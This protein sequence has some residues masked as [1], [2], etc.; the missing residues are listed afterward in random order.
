MIVLDMSDKR[1]IYEQIM[2]SIKKQIAMGVFATNDKLP[3]VRQLAIEMSI[4]PN[5]I[6]KAYTELERDGYIY[7]VKGKGNFAADI[8]GILPAR[9]EN[10]YKS[11][12]EILIQSANVSLESSDVIKHVENFFK[13]SARWYLIVITISRIIE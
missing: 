13:T 2:E 11:L 1:P 5:T 3:S 4:N 6:Q 9:Q 8:S 10:Y 7:S 12:D